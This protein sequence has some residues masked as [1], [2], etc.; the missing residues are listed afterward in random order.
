M[1]T[2]YVSGVSKTK[3]STTA[4]T[5]TWNESDMLFGSAVKQIHVDMGGVATDDMDALTNIELF[6][7]GASILR[8]NELQF[9]AF[10]S[11]LGKR[12]LAGATA[13]RFTIP[14]DWTPGGG[15]PPGQKL[16][17]AVTTDNTGAAATFRVGYTISD[18]PANRYPVLLAQQANIGASA[19]AASY[20]VT[21]AGLLRGVILPRTTSITGM[22]LFGPNGEQL[23]TFASTGLMLQAQ[24]YLSGYTTTLNKLLQIPEPFMVQEGCRIELTTDSSFASTDQIV[25]WTDVLYA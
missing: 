19:T 8:M 14:F 16:S 17:L 9:N 10:V 4:E 7:G 24:D 25:V 5:I 21:Q 1:A 22:N 11:T 20:I 3:T 2:K 12:E 23:W 18:A 15:A 6:A 13:L